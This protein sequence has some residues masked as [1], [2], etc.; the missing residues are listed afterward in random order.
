GVAGDGRRIRSTAPA[1]G[2]QARRG[3]PLAD[4][5]ATKPANTGGEAI[6][7]RVMVTTSSLLGYRLGPPASP[8]MRRSALRT[9]GQQRA[10]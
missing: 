3:S 9:T 5:D 1:A 7:V 6:D 2:A 4:R 8:G 10:E